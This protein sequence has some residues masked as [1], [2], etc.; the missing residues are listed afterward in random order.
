MF[1]HP[2]KLV[3]DYSKSLSYND[4][5]GVFD[6]GDKDVDDGSDGSNNN[7]NDNDNDEYGKDIDDDDDDY[8]DENSSHVTSR[9]FFFFTAP[10]GP[11]RNIRAWGVSDTSFGASWLPPLELNGRLEMY[12]LIYST[13]LEKDYSQWRF[14]PEA[15]NY[16]VV[17][18]LKPFTTYYFRMVAYTRVGRGPPTEMFVVKTGKGG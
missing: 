14:K 11:P 7:A 13:D 17:E 3:C 5:D 18:G 8:D 10:G 4:D 16:T 2:F 6:D 12:H 9:L 1:S 15:S